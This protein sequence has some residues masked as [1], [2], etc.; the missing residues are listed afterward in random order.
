MRL[1]RRALIS[2]PIAIAFLAIAPASPA[3]ADVCA[4]VG[5]STDGSTPTPIGPCTTYQPPLF[6]A[7]LCNTARLDVDQIVVTRAVCVP[8]IA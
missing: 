6:N 3:S 1:V 7:V 8:V 4:Q 2:V 5:I